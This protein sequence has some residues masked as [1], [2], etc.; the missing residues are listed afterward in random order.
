M[1]APVSGTSR[2]VRIRLADRPGALAEVTRLLADHTIDIVRLEVWSDGDGT[3][4]DDIT[5]AA[6][7]QAVLDAGI[8]AL[9]S[10][11]M[12]AEVLPGYWSLR[13]WAE[14]IFTALDTVDGA[15]SPREELDAVLDAACRLTN[16]SHAVLVTQQGARHDAALARWDRLHRTATDLDVSRIRWTGDEVAVAAVSRALE[17]AQN[18]ESE[19]AGNGGGTG[20]VNGLVVG[21]STRSHGEGVLA[22]LGRRPSFIPSEVQRLERFGRLVARLSHFGLDSA[23]A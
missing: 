10:V 18:P 21:L 1:L 13:D 7:E 16:T 5:L 2:S 15:A 22:V 8:G 20:K 14:E 19:P 11:T 17:G 23:P 9:A 4:W 12:E 3:A 6:P